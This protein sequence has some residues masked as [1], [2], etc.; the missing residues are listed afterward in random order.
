MDRFGAEMLIMG[1]RLILNGLL[2]AVMV[3]HF[4]LATIPAKRPTFSA[5]PGS[6]PL[7][8]EALV[9]LNS[10]CPAYLDFQHYLQPYL[11]QFGIPYTLLD[12]ATTAVGPEVNTYAV[13]II[14]HRRLDPNNLYLDSTEEANL[15][16]AV[17]RGTGLVNFDNDLATEGV[18]HYTFIQ[19]LFGFG[20]APPSPR[21]DI[22]FPAP[23]AHYITERH[24]PGETIKTGAMTLG[25]LRLPD[26]MTTLALSGH[27]PF[28][29]VATP[30]EG[31][32]VQW[33]TYDWMSHA[34][35][36]PVF[37][38]DDLVWRSIVWA[39]RKPFVMQ[40]LPPFVT[41][42]VDD[43][44]GSLEW[45][46][47]ANDYGFKPWVGI[48]VNDYTDAE[49]AELS[50][51][52]HN[53]QATAAIH[54]FD[55]GDFF[56]FNHGSGRSWPDATINAH[57]ALGTQWFQK[58]QIPFS[59]LVVGH[60][61]EIG[62]NA[63]ADLHQWG[64]EFIGIPM[65]PGIPY[66]NAAA[67]VNLGPYRRYEAGVANDHGPTAHPFFYGDFLPAPNSDLFNCLTE[68]RDVTGYEWY[69]SHDVSVSVE[70][71]TRWLKRALDSMV[72]A[73]L[74]THSYEIY[75]ISAADWRAI[76]EGV[77]RNI[78]DYQPIYVTLD[79]ACRYVR[80]TTTSKIGQSVYDPALRRV[81][82]T[83]EG[84]TDL[85][86][87]FYLFSETDGQIESV[88][89]DVP[90]FSGSTQVVY[91]LPTTPQLFP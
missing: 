56:Y 78:A 72:L 83:L 89:L 23:Q 53:G 86:T 35:K 44:F 20:Y 73:T 64:V 16:T 70:R 54:A 62:S 36:G 63:L 15:T 85:P 66:T 14:G 76:L 77:T 49:A 34:V 48:F 91:S 21:S 45:L 71:G 10:N 69:P 47:A 79:E 24:T 87:R 30:G 25:G 28:L 18:P 3:V 2:I 38:L 7:R 9:L 19:T 29:A 5:T 42:R 12:I 43:E 59:P 68:I 60:Y 52:V 13:L 81:T 27:E 88:L 32:A 4:I 74:F 90:I 8:A 46:R 37:G 11:D 22:T 84:R 65:D 31:R 41:M 82:T 75:P 58:H 80:A 51:L 57:F 40:G 1:K 6:A 55:T 50:T 67:W 33:G 61:Y 39:A 26:G 17:T